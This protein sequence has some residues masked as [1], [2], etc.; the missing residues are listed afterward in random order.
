MNRMTSDPQTRWRL[1][2]TLAAVAALAVLGG[3][4]SFSPDGAFGPVAQATQARLGQSVQWPR[5]ETDRLAVAQR[6]SELLA[7]PLAADDAVQVALLN[8]RGLRASFAELGITE[9]EVVQ[10]GR[11]PNPGFSF[12]RLKRGDEVELERGFHFN[13]ARLIAMPLIQQLEA[14]RLARVQADTTL[15]VLALAADTRKA[16][17]QA[18]AAEETVRYM[19]QVRQTAEA[20][21]ELARRMQQIGNFNKLQRAR[22]QAFY[23]DAAL[24][25]ARAEQVRRSTRERLTRLMGLWGPQTAFE[26]PA[27]LPDLPARPEDR[28]D[29]EA[30]ALAQRLDVQGARLAAEQTA[31]NLGLTKATRFV[32]VLELGVVHNSSNEAPTQRGWEIGVELPLFD[33]GDAR[34]ARA[35]AVYMQAVDRAAETAINARSEVREAYAAYRSAYDIAEHQRDE[36]VPLRKLIAEE[37]LLRYNG[38]L[39][40]VFELLADARLQIASVNRYIESLRDFWIA[41]ADLEL[42]LIGQPRLAAAAGPSMNAADTGGAGH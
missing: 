37:N 22:E 25:L 8:N 34:V 20:S 39:I 38:M 26:L 28:P 41:Q 32:N 11:L 31:R 12:A 42:A 15:A 5:S 36:L 10:A 24:N 4:A 7:R 13:V 6:V 17:I 9:A 35:E 16:Y 21:A 23:A 29:I 19:Q 14:R 18:L 33:W 27:R 30:V 40:G 1:S 2:A 3:C